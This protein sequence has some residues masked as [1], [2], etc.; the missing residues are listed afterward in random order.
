MRKMKFSLLMIIILS[1]V[2]SYSQSTPKLVYCQIVGWGRIDDLSH[3]VSLRFE[4]DESMKSYKDSL[5]NDA[6][7][8]KRSFYTMI[9]ALNFMAK[10]GWELTQT[11]TTKGVEP[12]WKH[13]YFYVLKKNADELDDE[14]RNEFLK[15]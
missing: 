8:R 4:F 9:D 6:S 11:Y 7:G 5:L 15:N 2:F 1:P 12:D 14:T 3:V 13:Y 10:E